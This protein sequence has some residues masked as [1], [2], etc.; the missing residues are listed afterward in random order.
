MMERPKDEQNLSYIKYLDELPEVEDILI[1]RNERHSVLGEPWTAPL[2]PAVLNVISMPLVNESE[3]YTKPNKI[4]MMKTIRISVITIDCK[5]IQ[6]D[7]SVYKEIP[8]NELVKY[9][10]KK[11]ERVK[12]H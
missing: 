8:K 1:E 2:A 7:H 4:C 5:G 11:S 6:L 3:K 12:I 9:K 10:T